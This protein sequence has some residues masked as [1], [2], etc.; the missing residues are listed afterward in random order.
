MALAGR[1]RQR[2]MMMM[3]TDDDGGDDD[4]IVEASVDIDT[5]W[6][7]KKAREMNIQRRHWRWQYN[8]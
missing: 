4:G 3:M 7:G 6:H 5:S 1:R 8:I 2:D